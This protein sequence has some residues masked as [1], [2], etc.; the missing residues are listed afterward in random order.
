ML[1]AQP[2]PAKDSSSQARAVYKRCTSDAPAMHTCLTRVHRW[3]IASASGVHGVGVAV[4]RLGRLGRPVGWR[5]HARRR[6]VVV[7]RSAQHQTTE[8]DFLASIDEFC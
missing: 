4:A 5:R 1:P 7:P 3:C 8:W 6:L 2:A